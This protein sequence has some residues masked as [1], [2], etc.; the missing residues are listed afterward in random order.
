MTAPASPSLPDD[1][2]KREAALWVL[3]RDR[4]FSASEQDEFM[5]WLA[6][7][8]LHQTAFG[9]QSW[10]WDE[11]DRLAGLNSSILAV[12]SA[13]P[14]L[15]APRRR[16]WE[17]KRSRL[18]WYLPLSFSAAA[19]VLLIF[20]RS[21]RPV[22]PA[23]L[24]PIR[25]PAAL[26][27][28]R[29]LADGSVVQ[30]NRGA[31]LAVDFNS[32]ER[33]VRLERGE[34]HFK[35]AKEAARAFVVSADGIEVRAVGTAFD[36]CLS[37]ESVE[38][39]VNEGHVR[40]VRAGSGD[41]GTLAIGPGQAV[42]ISLGWGAPPPRVVTLSTTELEERLA[43]R[44]RLLDFTDVPLSEIAAEFSRHNPTRLEIGD[45]TLGSFRLSASFRSDNL[46]GFVRLM[47]SQFGLVAEHRGETVIL[48]RGSR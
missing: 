48:R 18:F 13:D 32:A 11:L 4:G 41:E 22:P 37:P 43:W 23:A 28:E 38:V 35:V 2:T 5:Q 47:E 45:P 44:P 21:S 20:E 16:A 25:A 8:P 10:G 39:V 26:C 31:V 30:L 14:D 29:A 3:R 40:A 27:Q 33:R 9:L 1:A 42:S 46:E 19:A 34:A 15:L 24:A 6:A 7:D 17:R 12:S 36:V